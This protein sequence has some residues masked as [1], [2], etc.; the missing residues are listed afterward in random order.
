ME[1]LNH[2]FEKEISLLIEKAEKMAIIDEVTT[3][4][5]INQKIIGN[6]FNSKLIDLNHLIIE[7][8]VEDG[9]L[10]VEYYDTNILENI[11]EVQSN[12]TVKLKKKTKLF[13]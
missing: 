6:L 13:L 1:K 10:Y 4:K 2:I 8:K 9:K 12:R 3:D 7:T 5:E 11:V